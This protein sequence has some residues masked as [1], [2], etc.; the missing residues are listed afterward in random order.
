MIHSLL[1]W[2]LLIPAIL[3]KGETQTLL[4][5]AQIGI[6]LCQIIELIKEI[7][8]DKIEEMRRQRK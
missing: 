5:G 7:I 2:I 3:T 1:V 4:V 8:Q 6:L